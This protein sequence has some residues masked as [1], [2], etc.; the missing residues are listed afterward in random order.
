MEKQELKKSS[1]TYYGG[2]ILRSV[3]ITFN[4][5]FNEGDEERLIF[6]Q[7]IIRRVNE[8]AFYSA[9][10]G[11]FSVFGANKRIRLPTRIVIVQTIRT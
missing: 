6:F 2:G 8:Y 3:K 5:R 10:V 1:K 9:A 11:E 4:S 7:I